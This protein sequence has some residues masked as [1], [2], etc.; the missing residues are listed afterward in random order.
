MDPE[1]HVGA[2]YY[3]AT[4]S[5]LQMIVPALLDKDTYLVAEVLQ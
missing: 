1:T 2:L 5:G 3:P 4:H